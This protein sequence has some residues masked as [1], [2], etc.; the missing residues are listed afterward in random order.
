[1]DYKNIKC[2]V[3]MNPNKSPSFVIYFAES[4]SG[5]ELMEIKTEEVREGFVL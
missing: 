1:M 3:N 2:T 5:T 4:T